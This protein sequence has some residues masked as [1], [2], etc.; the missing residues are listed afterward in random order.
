MIKRSKPAS[1]GK[2]G[3]DNAAKASDELINFV[4]TGF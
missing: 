1:P 2:R 3:K 4:K